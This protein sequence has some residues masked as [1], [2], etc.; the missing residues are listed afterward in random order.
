MFVISLL[1]ISYHFCFFNEVITAY[2]TIRTGIE[3]ISEINNAIT[4]IYNIYEMN[5]K[6]SVDGYEQDDVQD[7]KDSTENNSMND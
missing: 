2:N 7:A 5:N 6:C 1:L 3:I 4:R